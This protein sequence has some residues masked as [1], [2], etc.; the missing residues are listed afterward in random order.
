MKK[1]TTRF[2]YLAIGVLSAIL[3]TAVVAEQI[4]INPRVKVEDI[5]AD[6]TFQEIAGFGDKQYLCLWDGDTLQAFFDST[7]DQFKGSYDRYKAALVRGI[8]GEGGKRLKIVDEYTLTT[9]NERE[10]RAWILDYEIDDNHTK[11]TYYLTKTEDAFEVLIVTLT[12]REYFESIKTRT[13]KLIET[14]VVK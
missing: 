8:K 14:A 1:I 9:A 3:T 7:Q 5:D 13:D 12:D 2:R 4:E 6:W 11:Q 10:F